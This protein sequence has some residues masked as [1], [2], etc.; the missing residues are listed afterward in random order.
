M[1]KASADLDSLV[2]ALRAEVESLSARLARIER[3]TAAPPLETA[4]NK[5][6][7][8]VHVERKAETSEP[9][10]EEVLLVISAAVAAFL[11]E[12]HHIRHVRL[13]SSGAWAV[14][15]RVT[16]QASHQLR[17]KT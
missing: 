16:I 15:G 8:P 7:G 14:Q 2:K 4:I 3:Q 1:S 13:I 9:V 12:R 5:P 10:S 11:G 6:N 17:A